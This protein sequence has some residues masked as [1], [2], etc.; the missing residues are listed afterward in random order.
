M[1]R[2]ED[3]WN[4]FEERVLNLIGNFHAPD[5]L[6]L[7]GGRKATIFRKRYSNECE[8]LYSK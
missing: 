8:H 5:V 2:S 6:E 7:G 4:T 1:P 3:A